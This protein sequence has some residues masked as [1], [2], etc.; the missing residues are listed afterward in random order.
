MREG[1]SDTDLALIVKAA[2]QR[3]KFALGGHGNAEGIKK[4]NDNRPMILIG[5]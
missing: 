1:A 2:L 5:G 3:K 4:A